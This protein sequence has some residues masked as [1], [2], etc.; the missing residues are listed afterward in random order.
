MSR[1]ESYFN[2]RRPFFTEGSEIFMPSGRER[3]SCF[4][5]PLELFYSRRI[6]K[7]LIDGSEVPLISG[8]KVFGRFDDLE[9]GGFLALTGKKDYTYQGQNLTEP[10]CIFRISQLK[11]N[12]F[13]KFDYWIII[14]RKAYK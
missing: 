4:Y 11:E 7:K 13:R 6:G 1:Y 8:T 2:E 10:Q 14:R 3:S 9:Y 5:R 12:N